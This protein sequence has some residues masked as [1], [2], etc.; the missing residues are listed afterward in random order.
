MDRSMAGDPGTVRRRR[1][2][3][4]ASG[5]RSSPAIGLPREAI[6]AGGRPC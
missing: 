6:D 2:V 4:P 1:M 3:A 5:L